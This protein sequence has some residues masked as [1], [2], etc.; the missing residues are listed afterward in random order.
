MLREIASQPGSAK[1]ASRAK[2]KSVSIRYSLP[3]LTI[4]AALTVQGILQ[5][6]IPKGVDFPYAFFYLI[7]AFVSAW[8]GGY[9]SGIVAC[10]LVLIGFPLGAG[11]FTQLPPID[12]SR[13]MLFIGVSA[14]ISR[15][16][17]TQRRA[18]EVLRA[19]NAELD[20]RVRDRTRELAQSVEQLRVEIEE[21]HRTEAALRESEERIEFALDAADIGRLDLNLMT[22][23]ANR[24]PRHDRIFGYE[25][26]QPEWTWSMTLEHI[27]PEDRQRVAERFEAAVQSGKVLECECRIQ[28]PDH[29]VRWISIRGRMPREEAGT[30]LSMLGIVADITETK[31][32]EQKLRTQ[33]ERLNLLDQ[34]TRAIGE[35][36]DLLSVL[37]VVI[38]TLEDSLP[39]DFG[40]VCLYDQ[41]AESLTVTCV[42]AGSQALGVELAMQPDSRIVIDQNGLSR[43]VRG[44]LVYEHDLADVPFPFAERLAR[45][46]LR[47]MVAAPL[48]VES[49]VFGVLI[50]A[51]READSFSSG[52]CEFLRQLSE[53]V[54]LAAHQGQIY[55]ALQQAYD[56]LRQTQ[57]TVMQ[58][59][60]LRALGQMAS[61]IAHDINNALSPMGLYTEWLLE[62]EPNLSQRARQY[63]T[64]IQ[65]AI[66]DV[67]QTVARMREF[68][69]KKDT[70]L[71]LSP[72][73][74]GPLVQQVLD[75]TRARW[76]DMPQQ[77]GL[78]VHLHTELAGHLPPI[79]GIESEIREALTNLI[80]N[81][82]DAMPNGGTL[83]LRSRARTSA[84]D[85]EGQVELE[86]ADTGIGMDED[87]RRR[88]LEP[89]FTT[90]GERGTGLGLAMV[91]GVVQR[92]NAHVE[93]ESAPG[94]GTTMRLRFPAITVTEGR[95]EPEAP[96][97]SPARM[98]ILVVDDDPLL[99]KSLRDTLESDGHIVTTAN[100][101]REGIAAFQSACEGNERFSVVVTDLGMPYVDGR[102]VAS[103]VKAISPSTPVIL[104]TG[105]GQRMSAEGD[106]PP[107]VDRILNKPPKLRELRGALAEMALQ[108]ATRE[109][110]ALDT[111][112]ALAP[113]PAFR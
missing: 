37:Q 85:S 98:R 44:Q 90:K 113:V 62:S 12:P 51:R 50:A 3:V 55:S 69:R 15:T 38:R 75:L 17:Q 70:E 97:P 54:A 40:C 34:I 9:G 112:A 106:V 67:A 19:G 96:M 91:Y 53:H 68:Y 25:A 45:A 89:F 16:A 79:A 13:L 111:D 27:L 92:H 66:G 94:V 64:T 61:G 72:V 60:R 5:L 84:S 99:I 78:T 95:V 14:L 81:A 10:L 57:H 23:F 59:E 11:R 47:A 109:A 80:F 82:L 63:L 21:H 83:T 4:A 2:W 77:K 49:N 74:L 22:G 52:E 18:R 32:S 24:S 1:P 110:G 102:K 28:T 103:A 43:C 87:T 88:C 42:G 104:L 86:V 71:T 46:G 105:W 41:A 35:R 39:I 58:Q 6:Y 33:L 76:N 36:Q 107:C 26:L 65:R 100:G 48:L 56:D 108:N 101:G 93:I 29:M 73:D 20:R 7:A 30:T 8:Y 31:L